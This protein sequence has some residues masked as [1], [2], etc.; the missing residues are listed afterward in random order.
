V[1]T[2]FHKHRL[3]LQRWFWAIWLYADPDRKLTTREFARLVGV[4][5][6]TAVVMMARLR[7]SLVEH[8]QLV[9]GIVA[10]L[11][12]NGKDM[13]AGVHLA[14]SAPPLRRAL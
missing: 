2:I 5:R 8:D 10:K 14:P 1:N 11:A 3:Q 7:L 13:H 12:S 4:N 9:Q 6:N